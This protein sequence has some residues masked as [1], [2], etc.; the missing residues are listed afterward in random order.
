MANCIDF[1]L[2]RDRVHECVKRGGERLKNHVAFLSF[3]WL[4]VAS[5]ILNDGS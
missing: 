4:D 1:H 3:I 2:G 5:S